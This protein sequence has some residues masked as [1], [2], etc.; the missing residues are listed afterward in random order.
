MHTSV[1]LLAESQSA[2]KSISFVES[3]AVTFADLSAGDIEA[4]VQSGEG[5]DKAGSYGIQ[6]LGSQLV[7]GING[8]YFNVMGL[9]I[10]RLSRQIADLISEI[11]T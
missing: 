10:H 5:M 11:E 7:A 1:S 3:T 4:Y 2:V 6:G 8:C 9:P